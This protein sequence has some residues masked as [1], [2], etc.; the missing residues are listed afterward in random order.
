MNSSLHNDDQST[1]I[2]PVSSTASD[3][4]SAESEPPAVHPDTFDTASTESEPPADVPVFMADAPQ[5][6]TTP[7]IGRDVMP[8]KI[9]SGDRPPGWEKRLVHDQEHKQRQRLQLIALGGVLLIIAG[10]IFFL[11]SGNLF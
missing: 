1:S 2:E 10:V 5:L 4:A 7:I 6:D 8:Q 11:L 3:P 9:R